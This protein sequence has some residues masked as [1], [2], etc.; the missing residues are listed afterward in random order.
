MRA[1]APDR[2]GPL[3]RKTGSQISAS[4][5]SRSANFRREQSQQIR[6]LFDHLVGGGEQ[7]LRDAEAERLCRLKIDDQLEFCWLF[8]REV[9]RFLR[10]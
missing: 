5:L 10:L 7:C 6:V 2:S 8:D 3:R 1:T 4:V 9:Q